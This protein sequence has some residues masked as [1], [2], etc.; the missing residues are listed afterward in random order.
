MSQL[1][2]DISK[3]K[4]IA[5]DDKTTSFQHKDGHLIR[6]AHNVLSPK[7]RQA[8][9]DLPLREDKKAPETESGAAPEQAPEKSS[10]ERLKMALGGEANSSNQKAALKENTSK[11][12]TSAPGKFCA[13]CGARSAECM[14]NGGKMAEGGPVKMYADP[15]SEVSSDDDA[16]AAPPKAPQTIINVG[17]PAA[18]QAPVD[19][20]GGV[21]TPG[22]VPR[23]GNGAW[24]TLGKVGSN[25]GHMVSSA[26][27]TVG[28]TLFPTNN[29]VGAE[30]A[31]PQQA[32]APQAAPAAPPNPDS[33][34]ATA[35]EQPSSDTAPSTTAA[36]ADQSAFPLPSGPPL[37]QDNS[38]LLQEAPLQPGDLSRQSETPDAQQSYDAYKQAHQQEFAQEDAKFD[39]DLK[40]GHITPKTMSDL[41]ARKS[42]LGKIG[43]IFGLLV[44]GAGAGLAH[45]S[46]ALLG[47]M[48][49]ELNNDLEAQKQSKSNAQNLLRMNQ[50]QQAQEANIKLQGQQGQLTA[51]QANALKQEQAIKAEAFTRMQQNRVALAHLSSL[52]QGLPG[53]PGDPT[54]Q[55]AQ[56]QLAMLGPVLNAENY[57]IGAVAASKAA[58]YNLV[59]GTSPS[60]IP[61]PSGEQAFQNR[62]TALKLSGPQGE[63]MAK[64]Q[65][66]KHMPGFQGQASGPLSGAD[67]DELTSGTT[68]QKQLQNFIDWTKTHSGDINPKDRNTGMAM[69]ASLQ[70][71]YRQATHGGVYKESETNFISRL[72]DENPTKFFNSVRSV[73]QLE[74]IAKD[75]QLRVDQKAKSLGFSGYGAGQPSSQTKASQ[76]PAAASGPPEGATG[77]YQGKPV[78]RVNG[79]WQYK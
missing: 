79:R 3:M 70:G 51:E 45:Q 30:Q 40:N 11:D 36:P 7:M 6:I 34:A 5:Q 78:V 24:D 56:Q 62:M 12:K 38:Q 10:A 69:A 73:P 1:P 17:A 65:E 59:S 25:L 77:T 31:S 22:A 48:Q 50:A 32:P 27:G 74:A 8:L 49:N 72:I 20:S 64:D 55:Q 53:N 46:P 2:I 14:C 71:A 54:Q 43:T 66:D 61:P 19:A 16:P 13:D 37:A 47:L 33:P 57:Q 39:Q 35:T 42:T 44:G 4:K 28:N 67:R 18:S 76:A 52:A 63:A 60:G 58:F 75:N 9:A 41:F 15:D 26:A 21:Q 29:R 23:P 68:F